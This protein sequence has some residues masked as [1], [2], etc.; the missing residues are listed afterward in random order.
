MRR[1][2][3][4]LRDHGRVHVDHFQSALLDQP[5][6]LA[7]EPAAVDVLE[8]GIAVG[9]ML[10]YVSQAGGT[11]QRVAHG[12][13]QDIRVRVPGESL[14][15]RNLHTADDQLAAAHQRVGVK[16]LSDS[17][18][19]KPSVCQPSGVSSRL[20]LSHAAVFYRFR[21]FFLPSP[22]E[23]SRLVLAVDLWR[24]TAGGWRLRRIS[25]ARAR[26]S[27]KVTLML[28]VSPITSL[29]FRPMPSMARASS[30]TT[31]GSAARSASISSR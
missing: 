8:A 13:Y 17:H 27:A 3:R 1:Q 18:I 16:T 22:L 9:E 4:C 15:V 20:Q 19:S 30:V 7:Q 31:A 2:P 28:R 25:S 6:D 5:R 21:D 23:C 26:S 11:Q 24:L 14:L 12:V 10:P 29:G